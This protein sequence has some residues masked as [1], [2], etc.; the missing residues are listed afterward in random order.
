MA[1]QQH[2]QH[3]THSHRLSLLLAAAAGFALA[4]LLQAFK[5]IITLDEELSNVPLS[6]GKI[7]LQMPVPEPSLSRPFIFFHIPM[8]AGSTLRNAISVRAK[9]MGKKTLVPCLDGVPCPTTEDSIEKDAQ[10]TERAACTEIFLG[11]F[12]TKLVSTISSIDQQQSA[13]K[14]STTPSCKRQWRKNEPQ[15]DC[16]IALREPVSRTISHYYHS[17]ENT[18]DRYKGRKFKDLSDEEVIDVIGSSG[19]NNMVDYLSAWEQHRSQS[20]LTWD[21]KVDSAIKTLSKCVLV[22]VEDWETSSMLIEKKIPWLEKAVASAPSKNRA[23]SSHE[24]VDDLSQE[25]VNLLVERL[26]FDIKLY[27]RGTDV[28]IEQLHALDMKS[29]VEFRK[30]YA[31]V[32][33]KKKSDNVAVVS[34]T[35]IKSQSKSDNDTVASYSK[36]FVTKAVTYVGRNNP[37]TFWDSA[38]FQDYIRE[39]FKQ[40][41]DEGFN[42]IILIVPWAGFQLNVVPPKY[43]DF[44]LNRLEYFL[45]VALEFNLKIIA[46][47]SYPHSFNKANEPPGQSR[48]ELVMVK[49]EV[50]PGFR[51]GWIDYMR[52]INDIFMRPKYGKIYQYSFFSW[53][54]FFCLID[55][56]RAPEQDRKRLAQSLG[57]QEYVA[58]KYS[59]AEQQEIFGQEA[60]EIIIPLEGG[61]RPFEAFVEFMDFKWW[62]LMEEAR[63]VHPRLTMEIR[64]DMETV[65]Y[66]DGTKVGKGY[67]LHTEDPNG[68]PHQLYWNLQMVYMVNKPHSIWSADDAV[69]TLKHMLHRV[70]NGGQ[71]PAILGQFNFLD[72]TP[73]LEHTAQLPPSV[74][75]EFLKKAAPIIKQYT[76]GYGLWAYRNYRQSE[77]FNGSFLR[78]LDG[79]QEATHGDGRVKKQDDGYLLLFGGVNNDSFALVQ[80]VVQQLPQAA[81]DKGD[82][83]MQLCFSLRLS[84][85]TS[86]TPGSD[87]QILWNHTLVESIR[88]T[89]Y[90]WESHCLRLPALVD[91]QSFPFSFKV[92]KNSA[93]VLDNVEHFCHE[94]SMFIHNVSNAI[95]P[96]CGNSFQNFNHLLS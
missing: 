58:E 21:E 84:D 11:H 52:T 93:V 68:P 72:N 76:H 14:D 6:Q 48:C 66:P 25:H 92:P 71:V 88:V 18:R 40:L 16:L 41:V 28:Y 82:N 50:V 22:V 83:N 86:S 94:H 55:L 53:E 95:I 64:V 63:R 42:T 65:V 33:S 7:Q 8:C 81:C 4:N 89:S 85:H 20:G 36:E 2:K 87:L 47:V 13:S 91:Y 1:S 37:L 54:D 78:G 77:V 32:K 90:S 75:E 12:T 23:K 69:E 45:D 79:W 19:G 73:G 34:D 9:E 70:T 46:R 35:A 38:R 51:Q 39:D 3:S 60:S 80:Q 17:I 62:G 15:Y 10:L 27:Q 26:A 5:Y 49:E 43:D 59:A 96:E 74:C 56:L 44:S 57:F 67:N 29:K 24:K 61:G 30:S 31:A